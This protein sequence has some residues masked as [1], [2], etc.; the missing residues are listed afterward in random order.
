MTVTV[1][2]G[3]FPASIHQLSGS[4]RQ[5]TEKLGDAHMS[6]ARIR[7]LKSHIA[8]TSRGNSYDCT[9]H[10]GSKIQ[11]IDWEPIRKIEWRN[12]LVPSYPYFKEALIYFFR[13]FEYSD[14][15]I[16]DLECAYTIRSMYITSPLAFIFIA[17][18]PY[19]VK[20]SKALCHK[21]QF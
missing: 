14:C 3:L 19:R 16:F 15:S 9:L 17:P 13:S 2:V 18:F 12:S 20:N 7:L 8:I 10:L 21:I 1:R 4:R 6:D 11:L 5:Q